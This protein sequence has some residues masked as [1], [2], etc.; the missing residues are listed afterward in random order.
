MAEPVNTPVFR[1]NAVGGW[2]R[3]SSRL[4]VW[5][6]AE[7]LS[8]QGFETHVN[9]GSRFDILVCQK[10]YPFR[11]A[12]NARQAG[13]TVL[14]DLDDADFDRSP[15]WMDK[16]RR[17]M[18]L[19][20]GVTTGSDFLKEKLEQL[21]PKA[22]V[23]ENPVDVTDQN[24]FHQ[25]TRWRGKSVWFGAPENLWMLRRLKLRH[26]VQT[27]TKG[28]DIPFTLKTV[29]RELCEFDIALLPVFL[30]AETRAKNANR[31]VKCAALG[32]PFLASDTPE[33]RKAIH[34]IGVPVDF[35]VREDQNW[36]ERIESV[37]RD[38]EKWKCAAQAC[39]AS[40]WEWYGAERVFSDWLTFC[41]EVWKRTRAE[42]NA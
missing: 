40:A 25:G 34:R 39:R 16:I 35:L 8:K 11:L 30:N 14:F 3:A 1:F 22:H 28:G 38:Y 23:L 21:H 24:I 42:A 36:D 41:L 32:L 6:L 7:F 37:A 10:T 2:K 29:D 33:H 13:K 4:R 9:D 26:P 20:H 19:A 31:L 15:R 18:Q 17:F 12:R 27:L 5:M